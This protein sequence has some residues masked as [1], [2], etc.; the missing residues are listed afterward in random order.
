MPPQ[1][2]PGHV[3]PVLAEE[4]DRFEEQVQKFRRE[5]VPATEFRL[6][7]L[8]H[9]VYGQRQPN[10]Q[11]I[12][13]KLPFGGVTADQMEAMATIT[14]EYSKLGRGHITTRQNV[15][16]YFV[17][18]DDSPGILRLLGRVGLTTREACAHTVRNV[19]GCAYAGVCPDEVFD[20]TPYLVAYARNMLRNPIC[21]RLPRKWK[22]AFA[23]CGTDCVSTAMHDL[24]FIAKVRRNGDGSDQKGFQIVVG[25][26]LSTFPRQ[27]DV[28]YDFVPVDGGEYITRAEAMLRVFDREGGLTGFLRKNLNK[29]RVKFLVHK[30]GIDEFRRQVEEELKGDWAR[31]PKDLST[32]MALAPEGPTVGEIPTDGQRPIPAGFQRWRATNVRRQRQEGC[33]AVTVTVPL[34]N[35]TADQ[36]RGLARIMRSYSGGNGRTNQNQNLVLRW[37][38]EQALAPLYRDLVDSGLGDS[39][40]GLIA[41]VASCPGSD[42]CSLAITSSPAMARALSQAVREMNI[43][44]PLIESISIKISGCPNACSQHHLAG[45]GLH[46]AAIRL[47]RR[48]VPSYD[49]FLG[50]SAN[51]V[52]RYGQRLTRIPAKRVPQA[53]ARILEVYRRERHDGEPFNDFLDRFG[54]KSFGPLLAEFKEVGPV[55]Q[56]IESYIDWGST[57][58]FQVMRGEGECAVGE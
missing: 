1:L 35:I 29:A 54:V 47:G 53:V 30:L 24:G 13:V 38:P 14:A 31:E 15:Q 36:F 22:T 42:S 21:Q 43:D 51:G 5:E 37:V 50:G 7:R 52:I 10:V 9:G 56:E 33:C 6:F 41:D 34:G 2:K 25:G 3:L 58:L 32:L 19:T 16:F 20:A 39:E 18:L 48:E 17:N 49:L 57:V 40:A 12:R 27:A 4:I 26:G 23:G 55:R 28:I 45:I 8:Q 11:M 46:G 44:D